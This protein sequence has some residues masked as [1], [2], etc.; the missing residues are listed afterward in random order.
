MFA[1]MAIKWKRITDKHQ[2]QSVNR[3]IR[4]ILAFFEMNFS[5]CEYFL[6]RLFANEP[7]SVNRLFAQLLYISLAMNFVNDSVE[8]QRFD[9]HTLNTAHYIIHYVWFG[10]TCFHFGS[11]VKTTTMTLGH[12]RRVVGPLFWLSFRCILN[13]CECHVE[14]PTMAR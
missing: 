13:A 11:V 12:S 3:S 4:Q 5:L 2:V 14:S 6:R 7:C 10:F 8:K 1:C 9:E